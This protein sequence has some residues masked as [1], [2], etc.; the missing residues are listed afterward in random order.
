[1]KRED[2]TIDT[3]IPPMPKNKRKMPNKEKLEKESN[4]L[5]EEIKLYRDQLQELKN[6]GSVAIGFGRGP[7]TQEMKD[8]ETQIREKT[9]VKRKL[10]NELGD[11]KQQ[12]KNYKD[13]KNQIDYNRPKQFRNTG[14]KN[15][16]LDED[17]VNKRIK[18]IQNKIETTSLSLK[19]EKDCIKQIRELEALKPQ[20]KINNNAKGNIQEL[21]KTMNNLRNKM[22]EIF[23]DKEKV[24]SELE[25]YNSKLQ[26]L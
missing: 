22:N 12:L 5:M 17:D 8:L 26:E 21:N 11:C 18:S 10:L 1:M 6:G 9:S 19:E 7:K 4:E 16:P 13:E 14:N 3:K 15:M 2:I 20:V 24:Q 23:Q 25:I